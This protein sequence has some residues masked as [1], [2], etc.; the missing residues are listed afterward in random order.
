MNNDFLNKIYI[1]M[2]SDMIARLNYGIIPI[3][4]PGTKGDETESNWREWF[5][6]YLPKRYKVDK[7]IIIDSN[8]NQS[9]QIDII[10]YDVQY[11]YL[12][13]HHNDTLLIPA[14]SVYAVFEVKPNLNKATM[15]Y[16]SG[17]VKSVRNLY[18]SSAPIKHAGGQYPPK[19]LHEIVGGL[20]TTGCDWQKPIASTVIKY[21]NGDSRQERLDVVS[22]IKDSTYIADN[23]IFVENYIEGEKASINFCDGENSLVFLLLNLLK[24]L[25]DIGTV[26]AIDFSQYAKN[27]ESKY[28]KET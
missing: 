21:I 17:K 25:Q 11:S 4:H 1:T 16:A 13:L 22:S 5:E 2:Q 12:V 18:R 27:I 7:G 3:A 9:E 20:L 26:P 8:G 28:Y 15:E 14:E 19:P 24:K 6:T 23:N 10:I